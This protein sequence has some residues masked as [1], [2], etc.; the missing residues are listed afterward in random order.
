MLRELLALSLLATLPV[1]A[2]AQTPAPDP[3]ELLKA[4]THAIAHSDTSISGPGAEHLLKA[5][6]DAQFVLFGEEHMD[7]AIPLFAAGLYKT[8][9]DRQGFKHLVL[10]QSPV[11]IDD[12]L[13]PA[14]R[15]DVEKIAA[16]AKRYPQLYEFDTDEDLALLALAGRLEPGAD[17]MWGVEQATSAIRYLEELAT[18]ARNDL[19]K[20]RVEAAL[21]EARAADA[22]PKYSVNWLIAAGTPDTLSTLETTFKAAPGTRASTLLRGLSKSAEIFGYY[23]RAEAGE[24]VGLFNNTVREDELKANFLQRYRAA[25][26]RGPLPKAMFK[27]GANH[28]YHGRNPT[29][30]H[31]IGNLA[32]ELA[33]VNGRKAYGLYVIALGPD[34]VGYKDL[35]AWMTSILPAQE[36]TEPTL[37]DLEALRRYQRLFRDKVA[38]ADQ[39][40][41][42]DLMNGYQALVLLPNSRPGER[43]L[44]G[45]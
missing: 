16:H 28:L 9:H 6:T 2:P 3:A 18:L 20:Q 15:G 14:R 22:E 19:S 44:G 25:A 26:K 35:P 30:A 21:A 13:A 34:Y 7:H 37:V 1:H 24:F 41:L 39:W 4:N 5:T 27:F 45:R 8:L 38:P 10:E 40:M 36:P 32:H 23:R 31:P 17:A 12:A 11:A 33:I 42:R 29:N 43:K